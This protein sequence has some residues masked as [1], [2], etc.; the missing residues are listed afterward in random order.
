LA[1]LVTFGP[2]STIS[3]RNRLRISPLFIAGFA[4]VHVQVQPDRVW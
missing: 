4:A 2:A 3:G 1:S